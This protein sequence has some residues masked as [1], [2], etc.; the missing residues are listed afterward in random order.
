MSLFEPHNH[1]L[2]MN[3]ECI[4][5]CYWFQCPMNLAYLGDAVGINGYPAGN[6]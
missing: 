3:D 2:K 4:Y 5:E 1:D 6:S